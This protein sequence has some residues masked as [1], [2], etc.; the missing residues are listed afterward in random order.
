MNTCKN[1]TTFQQDLFVTSLWQAGGKV[2]AVLS[3]NLVAT[4]LSLNIHNLLSSEEQ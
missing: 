4:W 2:V 3:H 1:L